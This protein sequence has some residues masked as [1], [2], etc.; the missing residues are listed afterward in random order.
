M[1]LQKIIDVERAFTALKARLNPL[2]DHE[3][4]DAMA[5]VDSVMAEVRHFAVSWMDAAEVEQINRE[6]AADLRDEAITRLI[7][8][9]RPD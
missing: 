2:L 9:L 5:R 6:K 1:N 7:Q 4:R 3:F 8:V